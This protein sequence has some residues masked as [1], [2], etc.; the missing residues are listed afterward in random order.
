V[1]LIFDRKIVRKGKRAMPDEVSRRLFEA[2]RLQIRYDF[3]THIATCKITLTGDTIDAVARTS[4]ETIA[5]GPAEHATG[6][7]QAVGGR[8]ALSPPGDGL[9][10]APSRIRTCA[11][12]SGGRCSI[13]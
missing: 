9:C 11:H 4:Q 13:P 3:T 10:C 2:L 8:A 5:D 1:S 12:G 6:H 7:H